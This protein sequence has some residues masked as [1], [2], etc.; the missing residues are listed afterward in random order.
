MTPPEHTVAVVTANGNPVEPI[1][2]VYTV[3]LDAVVTVDFVVE[4]GYVLKGQSQWAFVTTQDIAFGEGKFAYPTVRKVSGSGT[5]DDP[6]LVGKDDDDVRAFI[7]EGCLVLIGEGRA[8]SAPWLEQAAAIR[9]MEIASGVT[10]LAEGALKGLSIETVNGMD[11]RVFN[12]LA[13]GGVC[14][15]VTGLS[16]DPDRMAGV[17][18]LDVQKTETLEHPEWKSVER[19]EVEVPATGTSGFFRLLAHP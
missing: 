7:R 5:A 6:W 12:D 10:G 4:S 1:E 16:V 17:L 15:D 9:R 14:A 8:A 18:V 11:V 19:I 3:R 2:G 13:A